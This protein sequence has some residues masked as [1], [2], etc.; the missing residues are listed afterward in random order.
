MALRQPRC[1]LINTFGARRRAR[2]PFEQS[3]TPANGEESTP[4][5][6]GPPDIASPPRSPR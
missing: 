3:W 6:D 2:R 1:Y 5:A 4:A